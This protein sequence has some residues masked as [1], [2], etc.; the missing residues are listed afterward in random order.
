MCLLHMNSTPSR[1]R[2]ACVCLYNTFVQH[3]II[4]L[5]C[6]RREIICV[7]YST[8]FRISHSL[9]ATENILK[10]LVYGTTCRFRY[11]VWQIAKYIHDIRMGNGRYSRRQQRADSQQK[12]WQPVAITINLHAPQYTHKAGQSYIEST[13][14]LSMCPE[15]NYF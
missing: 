13:E 2:S 1:V 3:E 8:T 9:G 6:L 7:W 14:A 5:D 15:Y 4:C 12:H 10:H 11:V